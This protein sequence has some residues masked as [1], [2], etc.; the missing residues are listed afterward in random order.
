MHSKIATLVLLHFH[1]SNTSAMF[2][3]LK[4]KF[5]CNFVCSDV[6]ARISSCAD[7]VY[8]TDMPCHCAMELVHVMTTKLCLKFICAVA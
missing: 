6:P 5:F 1:I 7:V 8:E 3:L 4:C 2:R